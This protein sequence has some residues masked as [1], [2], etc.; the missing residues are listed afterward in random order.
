MAEYYVYSC[1]TR[2]VNPNYSVLYTTRTPRTVHAGKK[3]ITEETTGNDEISNTSIHML[4]F[5]NSTITVCTTR[6]NATFRNFFG[7]ILAT[8]DFFLRF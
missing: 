1:Y 5:F 8:C 4:D 7:K 3:I 2:I 6:P